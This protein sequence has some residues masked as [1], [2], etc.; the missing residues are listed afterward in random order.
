MRRSYCGDTTI[1]WSQ[2]MKE[3]KLALIGKLP[4]TWLVFTVLEGSIQAARRAVINSLD[5]AVNPARNNKD[6]PGKIYPWV[7]SWH[8]GYGVSQLLPTGENACLVLKISSLT[9]YSHDFYDLCTPSSVVFPG[10]Q[11]WEVHCRSTNCGWIPSNHLF[12]VFWQVMVCYDGFCLWQR[13]VSVMR[14]ESYTYL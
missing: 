3:I 8:E 10:P 1:S 6:W 12:S 7:Q 14:S 9:Y 4:P 13:D 2:D 5:P 11:T